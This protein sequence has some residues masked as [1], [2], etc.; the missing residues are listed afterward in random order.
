M[1]YSFIRSFIQIHSLIL[2]LLGYRTRN[3]GRMNK[4]GTA[5]STASAI[6]TS[7]YLLSLGLGQPRTRSESASKF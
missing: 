7:R 5:G 1:S 4:P 3:I 2:L 6:P